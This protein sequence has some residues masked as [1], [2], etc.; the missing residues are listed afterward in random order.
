[1]ADHEAAQPQN[2]PE[3]KSQLEHHFRQTFE[4]PWQ[5]LTGGYESD[6]WRVGELVVRIGPAWRTDAELGWIHDLVR[7]CAATIP[8]VVAPLDAVD[9]RTWFRWQDR[10]VLVLPFVPGEQLNRDDDHQMQQAARLLARIHRAGLQW[11][12]KRPRPA[13][14]ATAP[15]T[16]AGQIDLTSIVDAELDDWYARVFQ[17]E[18]HVQ[19]PVHGD[20]YRAN[21]LCVDGQVTGIIDWD[22][23]DLR[24]LVTEIAWAMWEFTH[25]AAGDDLDVA[26]AAR[27]LEAYRA[28]HDVLTDR[29]RPSLVPLIRWHLREEVRRS[30][31]AEQRGEEVDLGY[32]HAEI[33]AFNALWQRDLG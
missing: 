13:L 11:P 8:E 12:G 17:R 29:D 31:A 26:R 5:R 14:S 2:D 19:G 20:Y 33:R 16:P 25:N 4:L 23:S 24:P 22:E 3:L 1:M 18:P 27:F 15:P 21:L 6:V 9:G 10:P 30:L 7:H 32:R 28:E